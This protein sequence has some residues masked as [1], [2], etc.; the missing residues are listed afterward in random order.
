MDSSNV[1]GALDSSDIPSVEMAMDSS[2]PSQKIGK[3]PV[4]ELSPDDSSIELATDVSTKGVSD[5]GNGVFIEENFDTD[6]VTEKVRLEQE[7]MLKEYEDLMRSKT[8]AQKL[9]DQFTSTLTPSR[10]RELDEQSIHFT[11]EQWDSYTM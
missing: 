1:D 8:L 6:H 10:Q 5:K 4:V 7:R 11:D 9:A 2:D 3:V